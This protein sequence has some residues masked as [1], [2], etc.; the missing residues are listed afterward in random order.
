MAQKDFAGDKK[1]YRV[2]KILNSLNEKGSVRVAELAAEYDVSERSIQ[3]DMERINMTFGLEQTG[4]G[5]Y[6]FAAGVSLQELRL[7]GEQLS[8][9]SRRT[10]L[11]KLR[12][13]SSPCSASRRFLTSSSSTNTKPRR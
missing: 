4:K 9:T 12:C 6:A 10:A 3:R 1:Y 11:P 8:A 13:G 5:E 2:L 7:S